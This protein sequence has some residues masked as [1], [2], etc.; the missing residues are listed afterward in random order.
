MTD[1]DML[2][3]HDPARE[4][5]DPDAEPFGHAVDPPAEPVIEAEIP[6]GAA[7]KATP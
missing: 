3:G 7:A 4:N 5:P 1:R 2:Q 6:A